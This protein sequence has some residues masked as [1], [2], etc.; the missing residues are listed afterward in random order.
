[1]EVHGDLQRGAGMGDGQM[2]QWELMEPLVDDGKVWV[3][4]LGDQALLLV[5]IAKANHS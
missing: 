5:D 4:W 2:N 1:M 3:M